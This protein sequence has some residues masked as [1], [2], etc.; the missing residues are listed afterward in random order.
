MSIGLRGRLTGVSVLLFAVALAVVGVVLYVVLGRAGQ[1]RLA[2]DESATVRQVAGLVQQGRLP[3]PIPVAG[4]QVVQVL[5]ARLRVVS[6]STN[7][8]RLTA[9]LLP[10]ELRQATSGPAVTV[11]GSR[12]GLDSPLRVVARTVDGP[13][14]RRIVL[15]GE[16]FA[17]LTHAEHVLG[18]SLLAGFPVLLVLFGLLAWLVTGWTLRPVD[19]LRAGAERISGGERADRLPVPSSHDEIRALAQTLNSMLDRLA[20]SRTRQR[21]F[22]ADAAHELRSPLASMR[23]QI[24]VAQ[25]LGEATALE[26]DLLH[27]LK[28]LSALVDG[29]LML[30]RADASHPTG[31]T[32]GGEPVSVAELL[33]EVARRYRGGRVPVT[34]SEPVHHPL[35]AACDREALVRV[36]SNVADNAVRHARRE[37]RMAARPEQGADGS[38]AMLL[39][40]VDD[41]GPGIAEP[42]RERV[43][44]RFTRLDSSRERGTGGSGLGL[45]IVRELVTANAGTVELTGSRLGGLRVEIRLPSSKE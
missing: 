15:V 29:L 43:F 42:D 31:P 40:T 20:A 28:R 39:L 17:E 26:A 30:A 2:A 21:A 22:V 37:V 14:S 16:Q 18:V 32:A 34:V 1:Q 7:A 5:D 44:E 45:A 12:I 10:G 24:E 4:S 13:R 35:L 36:V 41:D 25:H 23:T 8:D 19:A 38:A 11:S 3:D 6:A 9:L 33:G 27:E